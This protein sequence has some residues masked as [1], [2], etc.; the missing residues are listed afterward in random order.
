MTEVTAKLVDNLKTE[1]YSE[2]SL[3]DVIYRSLYSLLQLKAGNKFNDKMEKMCKLLGLP[4]LWKLGYFYYSNEVDDCRQDI[5]QNFP[6]ELEDSI[7]TICSDQIS[8]SEFMKET[9]TKIFS[10]V[11]DQA[12]TMLEK[13]INI[14][15]RHGTRLSES[16][17]ISKC[18]SLLYTLSKDDN[19]DAHNRILML[20]N[21]SSSFDHQV[22]LKYK[23][24]ENSEVDYIK[25]NND[26]K[27]TSVQEGYKKRVQ[28][29]VST[30]QIGYFYYRVGRIVNIV[31]KLF[32]RREKRLWM[33]FW[34]F[35]DSY[36]TVAR[37][38]KENEKENKEKEN[39]KLGKE[40]LFRNL[41]LSNLSLSSLGFLEEYFPTD[42]IKIILSYDV[43]RWEDKQHHSLIVQR[44]QNLN[45]IILVD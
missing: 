40:R 34:S 38:K 41:F 1:F 2:I 35:V 16:D 9:A 28:K 26:G 18:D 5:S 15:K 3:L 25:Y 10:I 19:D 21:P 24:Y 13:I 20:T 12:P 32:P 42:V 44:L 4:D 36:Q 23:Y 8:T 45:K 14:I 17:I 33:N 37:E 29:N 31:S 43:F 7:R 11:V 30:F 39:E 27:L 22:S 6:K